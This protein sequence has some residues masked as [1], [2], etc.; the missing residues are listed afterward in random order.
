MKE[1][2]EACK[3]AD[4]KIAKVVTQLQNGQYNDAKFL[5][6]S[7]VREVWEAQNELDGILGKKGSK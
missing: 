4:E 2:E 3:T 6:G 5:A 7:T 1:F